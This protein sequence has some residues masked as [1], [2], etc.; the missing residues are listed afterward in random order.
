M[1]KYNVD[2]LMEHCKERFL[3]LRYLQKL[4]INHTVT[5]IPVAKVKSIC[6]LLGLATIYDVE[7]HKMDVE[8][9]FLN[10]DF[11]KEI[12]MDPPKGFSFKLK[13]KTN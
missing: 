5:S 9:T 8:M 12:Y 13:A 11:K 3:A 10:V 1:I 6:T 7:C 2:G 4:S